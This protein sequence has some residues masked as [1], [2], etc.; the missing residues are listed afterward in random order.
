MNDLGFMTGFLDA[1]IAFAMAL[2]ALGIGLFL[3]SSITPHKEVALIRAGN[4]AASVSFSV[5]VLALALPIAAAIHNTHSPLEIA[6]WSGNAVLFQLFAYLGFSRIFPE[7]GKAIEDGHVIRV[8][9][10]CALQMAVALL[11]AAVFAS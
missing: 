7:T 3:Y 2:V 9:P 11:N 10:L 1:F 6:V 5:T 8:L 4:R